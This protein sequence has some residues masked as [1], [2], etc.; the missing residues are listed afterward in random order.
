VGET[1]RVAATP[2]TT[3]RFRLRGRR[4]GRGGASRLVGGAGGGF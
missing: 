2:A 3:A 1:A 4:G